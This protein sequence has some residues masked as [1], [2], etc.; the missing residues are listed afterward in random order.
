MT[1]AGFILKVKDN[2]GGIEPGTWLA[3]TMVDGHI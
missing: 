1:G 2:G 3:T